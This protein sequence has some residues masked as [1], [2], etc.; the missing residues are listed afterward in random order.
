MGFME[1]EDCRIVTDPC[2]QAIGLEAY[3]LDVL[4]GFASKRQWSPVGPM[5]YRANDFVEY[6]GKTYKCIQEHEAN[7]DSPP[8]TQPTQWQIVPV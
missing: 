4:S 3:A 6:E 2:G 8:P 5:L 1:D 7:E